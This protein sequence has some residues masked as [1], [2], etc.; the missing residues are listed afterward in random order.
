[1]KK[2]VALFQKELLEVAGF[3][4]STVETYSSSVTAFCEF[5]ENTC[6]IDP[7]AARGSHLLDWLQTVKKG[8]GRSRLRQHQFAIKNFFAFLDR[9][10]IVGD[11]PAAALP[12]IGARHG[13]KH[14]A[15][16]ADTVF[17]LLDVI[18]RTTWLG[19]RNHLIV[20]MLWCL[21][22]R[23]G[24]LTGLTVGGFEPHHDPE[25]RIGLLRVRGKNKKQRALFVVGILYDELCDY[26]AEPE[27][28]RRKDQPL[29]PIESGK[30][31]SSCRIQKFFQEYARKAGLEVVLTPHRLR[32]SFATE[33]YRLGVPFSAIQGMLG[34]TRKSET[35]IYVHVPDD[36]RKQAMAKVGIF[37]GASCR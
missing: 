7:L 17:K 23:I 33:M 8:I 36:M 9:R 31:I 24:E 20:A 34:H 1:M 22:L 26:L 16:P 12:R 5:A 10:D 18:D 15:V 2:L 21:G 37:G 25:N 35:A 4:E 28:P 30:A 11:N 13:D 19:K 32:H 14:T 3:A 6:D 29:F 27:F